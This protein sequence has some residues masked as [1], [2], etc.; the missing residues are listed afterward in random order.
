MI[1]KLEKLAEDP[2]P[3]DAKRALGQKEK[4]LRVRVSDHRVLYAVFLEKN[5]VLAVNIDKRPKAYRR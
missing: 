3:Q 1:T 5:V 2:F 4:V